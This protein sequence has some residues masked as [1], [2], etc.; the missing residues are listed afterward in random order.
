MS[1]V[2]NIDLVCKEIEVMARHSIDRGEKLEDV[3]DAVF[4]HLF[5]MSGRTVERRDW[6]MNTANGILARLVVGKDRERELSK[7]VP[8]LVKCLEGAT[9]FAETQR[10]SQTE[11]DNPCFNSWL[12]DCHHTIKISSIIMGECGY[13]SIDQ[14]R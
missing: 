11:L 2:D 6:A 3:S 5:N 12:E 14:D 9:E 1:T 7:I 13:Q 8:A 10:G 4:E